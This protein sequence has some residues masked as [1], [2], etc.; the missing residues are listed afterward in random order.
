[1]NIKLSHKIILEKCGTVSFKRGEVFYRK[2][3]VILE[4]YSSDLCEARVIGNADFHVTVKRDENGDFHSKCS[5]PTLASYKK[6]CQ[7]IA[8]VLLAIHDQQSDALS[9]K[10]LTEGLMTLFNDKPVRSSRHQLH[11][12]KRKVL[13]VVFICKPVTIMDG[14]H[15]F[16]MEVKVGS[17]VVQDIR[18]FL[19]KT[20]GG[21]P[22]LLSLSFTYDPSLHCFQKETDAVIQ[23]LIHVI[24]DEKIYMDTLLDETEHVSN[25]HLL[26]I[27]PSAWENLLPLLQEAPQVKIVYNGKT[28]NGLQISNELLP[29]KFNLMESEGTGYQLTVKG[30]NEMVVLTSYRTALSD[31]KVIQLSNEDSKRLTDLKK[32][33]YTSGTNRIPIPQENMPFFMGKVVPGLRKMGDV[34]LSETVSDHF[35]KTPLVAKLYLDRVK[36]RLLAGL[37]F[38]YD[39]ISINPFEDPELQVGSMV[40]RD[41]EKEDEILQLME[42]SSFGQTEGGYFLH[43]EELE[44]TFLYH[45]IP[46]LQKLVQI[47]ATTAVRN[48]I[49]KGN[50]PPKIR[51]KMK[52]ERTNW[53]EFKFEMDG[54]PE[55]QIQEILSALEEKR[56]Y[57]RLPSGSLMSLEAREFEEIQRFLS[58]V[59]A[60]DEDLESGLNVPIV[61]GLQLLDSVDDRTTFTIEDSFRQFL[62]NSNDPEQLGFDVPESLESILRDYQKKGYKWMKTLAHY[63]F[64]GIL[65]D[66]MGLGKT[67][68]TI[69]FI[70]SVLPEIR[71]QKQPALIV[72]PSSLSYNWLSEINRFSPNIN[73]VVIDGT[74]VERS[75]LQKGM[76]TADVVITSYPLLRTDVKWYEKQIFHTAIFDEAQAFKN[77]VTQTAR[78]VKKI[79]AGCRFALTGTPVENSLEELWSIFHVV[80]PD[81][82][83]GLKE[84]SNLTQDKIA[85]RI[86]PFL[87]RRLKEEVLS[88]LPEK[89]E[90]IELVELL[91]EQKKLYAAYLAK[92]RYDAFKHLD[93]N[94]LRKNRIKILAGLTRLRQICCH[95]ALFVDGYEGNSAKFEQLL[96]II[97]E[98]RLSGR[99]VLIFSQFTKMLQ[100]IGNHLAAQGH[101]FF[102][103]DGQTPAEDRVKTCARFNEGERDLFLISLKAGGTGLNLTGADTVILYDIW[104]NPAVEDQAADRAH[105]M[106]QKKVV[107][108]IKL[109]SRGT[110]EEKMNQLQEKK[111]HLVEEIIDPGRKENSTLT[112]EDIQE[113]LKL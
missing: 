47:Y 46:K 73:A 74:K 90:S 78:A 24:N 49:T 17:I 51:V 10:E 63:G 108:V 55:K 33:L 31:G 13:D 88:E 42:E 102:Y 4:N 16:A 12:E 48:R 65:A 34:Q 71:T 113:L 89:I 30:M 103:L 44:Y 75:K 37:E 91:P 53:L 62:D 9:E 52:K 100:L 28:V 112:D 21:L 11:F 60:Q 80:F 94:T 92:L 36:N 39:T 50:A 22:S 84:Y 7:H 95:P 93:K 6:D 20:K 3:K 1:M 85:R 76:T 35:E 111:R 27:P 86:R 25:K 43:N 69:A 98:S 2:N 45:T 101:T 29:L 59:P 23:R 83:Q 104:W 96:H 40:V 72:C 56:K 87:L 99:R 110:I 41:V 67:L 38:H 54:I 18:S 14:S 5:C 81:L 97:E 57:Y 26:L 64:G 66:D 58:A 15:M 106:G 109:V 77:P 107:Q 19:E 70:L 32:M 79:E 105:R 8:A 61:R 82:F 68:Q